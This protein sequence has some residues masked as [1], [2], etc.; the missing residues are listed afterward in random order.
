MRS[1]SKRRRRNLLLLG[2][3]LW[4]PWLGGCPNRGLL[5][6]PVSTRRDLVESEIL[7][8]DGAVRDKV[9]LIDVS[10]ILMNASRWELLGKGEQPV[11]LLLEQLDKARKDAAV[12]AVILRINS[13]GG[14]VV[15]SELMHQE[16]SHFRKT[17]GKP[18]V[19][20]MM[21]V[22]ASGG[23]YVA[24]ACDEIMAQPSSVTGSIGVLMQM[25][26]VSGTMSKIGIRTDAI[27]SG[28]RKDAGS[29]L[30]AL[31]P[32]ERALFQNMVN[33]MYERFIGVVAAGR[34]K[35]DEPTI[36][37]LADGRVY[38]ATQALQAGLVD[39]ITS[40]RETVDVAKA[41]A[42]V[43]RARLVTY[44]RPLDYKPNYYAQLPTA[45]SGDINVIHLDAASLLNN[46]APRFMYLW[47]PGL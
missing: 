23:Y 29:P 38:T 9:A 33:D 39:R 46:T 34:P 12:K 37:S 30:R 40:M 2:L 41:K 25:V 42:G 15:A 18:V 27:A 31:T 26:D 22:A 28:P 43:K 13:P 8:D 20:V 11:S 16:I 36:R 6:Q 1:R 14:S 17:S 24:C 4:L 3:G 35:L 7:R 21:D 32:D 44:H 10:G 19:A 5:I 45:A 47:Q